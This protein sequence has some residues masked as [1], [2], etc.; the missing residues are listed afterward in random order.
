MDARKFQLL[1]FLWLFVISVSSQE[2]SEIQTAIHHAEEA[3][4][5]LGMTRAYYNLGRFYDQNNNPEQSNETLEKAL[6][7]AR[8]SNNQR[9]IA[10]ISN[11]LASNYSVMGRQQEATLLYLETFKIFM[12][13]GDT[14]VAANVLI[15]IGMDHNNRGNYEE[16]LKTA[17]QALELR[18]NCGDST[19]LAF[20]YQQIGEVYKQLGVRDKWKTS[21]ET[22][23]QLSQNSKYAT[24]TTR[25]SILNDW[26]G[27]YEAEK[28]YDKAIDAYKQM[29]QQCSAK[30]YLSGMATSMNNIAS[31]YLATG[32]HD[33]ALETAREALS[34]QER[35]HSNYG[36]LSAHNQLGDI[37][38]A[39]GKTNDA[40]RHFLMADQLA[41]Q[42]NYVVEQKTSANG[43]YRI[44]K[45]NGNW[46]E[47]L[48]H[49]E[50]LTHIK[51][52]LQNVDLQK[53][54]TELETKYQSEKKEQQIELLST[55][56]QLKNSRIRFQNLAIWSG[57]LIFMFFAFGGYAFT[58][59]YRSRQKRREG[60][61]EQKLLRSQMNPHFIFNSL[62]A[63]QSFMM[64]N[65][66]RKA[67]FYLGSFS[68]L[69]RSIL[70][71][72]RQ[73][74]ITLEEEVKTIENY[75][76]LHQLRLGERLLFKVNVTGVTDP[77]SVILPPML[78]QPFVENALKHGIE[79]TDKTG[80]VIVTFA[81]EGQLLV[82]TVDDNGKGFQ[83]AEKSARPQHNSY[84]LQ[85]FK[86][87][88]A[89]LKKSYNIEVQYS[90]E[91]KK[92]NGKQPSG[93]LVTIK[94]PVNL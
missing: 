10:T 31:V 35:R 71:H 75:F 66:S 18:L 22:A 2:L 50:K 32:M 17:L 3:N 4:D 67:A 42:F 36:R 70:H 49:H 9:A 12:E 51:D 81:K 45:M 28:H 33:K 43:L 68:S 16:A 30:D 58:K 85:I 82:I 63:I 87:R 39:M 61:L 90:I 41:N 91:T 14:T 6:E 86:E 93:T 89:I 40:H 21:L 46:K 64:K 74:M 79:Q 80:V 83:Q 19:N 84:A 24:F 29:H 13:I 77:E 56:N 73:E 72:S 20:F 25:I 5:T 48:L 27:I 7:L 52:S 54:L 38:L 69:M 78:V 8:T 62:G 44:A 94:I 23:Q 37:F 65:D 60:E 53:T 1:T 26:G 88:V 57:S 11:Y 55:E 59:Q 47:A 15:N 76:H 92:D 34:L